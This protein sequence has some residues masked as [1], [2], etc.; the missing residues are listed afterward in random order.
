MLLISSPDQTNKMIML[1]AA[2]PGNIGPCRAVWPRLPMARY[3]R[4]INFV[5]L[6]RKAGIK[7]VQCRTLCIMCIFFPLSTLLKKEE[8]VPYSTSSLT[9][10]N[11]FVVL[12]VHSANGLASI[13]APRNHALPK[14]G[15]LRQSS[16][17]PIPFSLPSRLN[18]LP[19]LLP[20]LPSAQPLIQNPR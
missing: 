10:T 8:R 12:V 14:F 11:F 5:V 9:T 2:Q 15:L 1:G 7:I 13:N 16:S 3:M 20:L 18:P 19:Q 4:Y 17:T 6:F